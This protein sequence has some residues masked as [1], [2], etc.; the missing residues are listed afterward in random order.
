MRRLRSFHLEPAARA[1]IHPRRCRIIPSFARLRLDK[2]STD[3]SGAVYTIASSTIRHVQ[4]FTTFLLISVHLKP[5][6]PTAKHVPLKAV[7]SETE[8]R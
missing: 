7:H 8:N 3:D 6:D 5:L 1:G 2:L 4:S